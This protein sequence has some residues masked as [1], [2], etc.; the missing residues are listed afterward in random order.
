M[1]PT[2]FESEACLSTFFYI[3]LA[4]IKLERA[5]DRAMYESEQTARLT[6]RIK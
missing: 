4:E 5:K 1:D 6:A 3:N 2:S